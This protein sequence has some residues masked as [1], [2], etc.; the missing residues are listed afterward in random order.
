MELKRIELMKQITKLTIIQA[1]FSSEVNVEDKLKKLYSQLELHDTL[2]ITGLP[3]K[4]EKTQTLIEKI[5]EFFKIFT[6]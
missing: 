5:K 3:K 6:F 2:Y 1:N 4:P